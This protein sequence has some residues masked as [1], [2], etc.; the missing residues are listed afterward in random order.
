VSLTPFAPVR[1]TAGGHRQT[2]LGYWVRRHLRWQAPAEDLV[3]EA[4]EDVRLLARVTW[5][6]GRREDDPRHNPRRTVEDR[7]HV[8]LADRPRTHE[9]IRHR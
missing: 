9:S 2:L 3:V 8:D 4:G 6:E 5:H 7:K 1:W